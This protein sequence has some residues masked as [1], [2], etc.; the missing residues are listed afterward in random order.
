MRDSDAPLYLDQVRGPSQ[1]LPLSEHEYPGLCL[2][3]P[4]LVLLAAS[5]LVSRP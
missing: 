5:N 4:L 2:I 1:Q 3:L